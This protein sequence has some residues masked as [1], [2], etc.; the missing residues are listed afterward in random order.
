M[1]RRMFYGL[2]AAEAVIL[3]AL[4]LAGAAQPQ[5]FS[6]AMAFPL[7]QLGALLRLMSGGGAVMRGAARRWRSGWGLGCCRL[8]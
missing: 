5:W 1:K 4:S 2:L 3:A 7:E 6:S 8:L